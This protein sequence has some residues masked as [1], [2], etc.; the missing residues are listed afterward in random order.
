[1]GG[2]GEK[3]IFF[4][5]KKR[6]NTRRGKWPG[7]K[8]I[9]REQKGQGGRRSHQGGVS[10]RTKLAQ[11]IVLQ[12]YRSKSENYNRIEAGGRKDGP[13]NIIWKG[14]KYKQKFEREHD[15]E[16][17][18]SDWMALYWLEKPGR[19]R[20][21]RRHTATTLKG[22]LLNSRLGEETALHCRTFTCGEI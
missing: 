5:S 18:V 13:K 6:K 20:G 12:P 10:T 22:P 3:K 11:L 2:G 9:N 4:F 19:Q 7:G 14:K 21:L 16:L 8:K 15:I 17:S 1:M